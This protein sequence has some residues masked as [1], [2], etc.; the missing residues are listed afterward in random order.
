[1]TL[2]LIIATV[3]IKER[4][5]RPHFYCIKGV[6]FNSITIWLQ[7]FLSLPLQ[8]PKISTKCKQT[9][10]EEEGLKKKKK[11]LHFNLSTKA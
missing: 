10:G 4:K 11:N 3:V 9:R 1:M 5:S 6:Q 8:G 7:Q 2:S